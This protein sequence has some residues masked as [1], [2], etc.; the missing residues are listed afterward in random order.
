MAP[1]MVFYYCPVKI[2]NFLA[3]KSPRLQVHKMNKLI[4]FFRDYASTVFSLVLSA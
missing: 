4:V 2:E 1:L 3:T